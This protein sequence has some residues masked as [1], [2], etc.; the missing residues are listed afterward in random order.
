MRTDYLH[1]TE[2]AGDD[3]S[4]EQIRRM[5][6][7][8]GWA[9][10]F[11]VN[12]DVLE[13]ACGT[14]QGAGFIS[15]CANYYLA[16]DYSWPM[17]N[18]LKSH[19]KNRVDVLQCSSELIPV[20]N[21]SFDVILAFESIYYFPDVNRFIDECFRVLRNNGRLLIVTA[22]KDLYDFNPSPNSV[23]YYGVI[24]LNKLLSERALTSKFYGDVNVKD[25][26][27]LQKIARPIKWSAVKL[28][29]MPKT[30][31]TKKWLKGL[32]FGGL[33]TMPSE[34]AEEEVRVGEL[35]LLSPDK[36][37]REFK[38]ILCEAQK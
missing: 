11:C 20:K 38:V 14:G 1:I 24:E 29:L 16:S 27:I 35:N 32:V 9:R 37:D 19:Y 22:N 5:Y 8:Y 33:E 2:L 30:N 7:R 13:I 12:N 36:P 15:K 28:N 31:E 18:T 25:V 17:V 4:G 21:E 10:Q 34:L 3:V 26:S 6:Y 23:A